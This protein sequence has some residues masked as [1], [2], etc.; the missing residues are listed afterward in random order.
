MVT[1]PAMVHGAK[2]G[3]MGCDWRLRRLGSTRRGGAARGG[4]W[5]MGNPQHEA[6]GGIAGCCTWRSGYQVMPCD[7]GRDRCRSV[8]V[9]LLMPG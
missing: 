5:R 1:P 7:C 6:L 9:T 2:A 8:L 4:S 3:P